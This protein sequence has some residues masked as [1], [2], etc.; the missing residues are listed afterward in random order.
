MGKCKIGIFSVGFHRY[1]PQFEGLRDRLEEHRV[2]FE[3]KVKSF[4]LNIE[5]I[6]GGLVDTVERGCEVGDLF[7]REQVDM[8]FCD[9]TTYVQSSFVIPVP[10]RAKA[11]MVLIGLQPTQ[12]MEP[13]SATTWLQLEHDNSTSLP[14]IAC[15]CERCD[16]PIMDII[17]GMLH[18]DERAWKKIR[19]WVEVTIVLHT[20]K[21][22]RLGFMGHVFEWMMDMQFDP[23]MVTGHFGSH[24]E[25][26]EMG[27]LDYRV[28]NVTDKQLQE[29]IKEVKDFFDFPPPGADKIAGPVT[30]EQL[31]WS[32]K[33]A[34]GLEQL[35][36]DYNLAGLTYYYHG[37]HMERYV[38]LVPGMIVGNSLLTGKGVP[39]AGE[40]D[41][42]N[43]VAMLIMNR[44]GVGGSFAELHPASFRD[45]YILIGHDGPHDVKIADGKP[46]LRGLSVLHGKS[47][48]GASVEFKLKTGPVSMLGITQTFDG[49]FRFVYAEGESIP[50]PIPA[51]GN[52]NT[53]CIFAPDV[54]TFVENWSKAGPTH[55]FALSIGHNLQRIK[56]LA[57]ILGIELAVV[58]E[59]SQLKDYKTTNIC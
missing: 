15:G 53:K 26:L 7:A 33:V 10:Q 50:G 41:M 13:A 17:F 47:G 14:E 32:S 58:A 46:V 6:S 29:K 36:K 21:N 19:E 12:G 24:V 27:D 57:K 43:C 38:D 11:P 42:K 54:P 44:F 20:L 52:T 25:M 31:E 49:K 56:K 5:I 37:R 39:V 2:T 35:I 16:I 28:Q 40:G 18:N 8:I 4:G 59:G 45:G 3:N 48:Q 23:T 9:V 1:W 34:V 22:A 55:H 30:K 51:T